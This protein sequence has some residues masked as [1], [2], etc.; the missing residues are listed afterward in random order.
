MCFVLL[1]EVMHFNLIGCDNDEGV[2]FPVGRS[3]DLGDGS[4][5]VNTYEI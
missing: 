5:M 3:L 4:A 1:V 2:G